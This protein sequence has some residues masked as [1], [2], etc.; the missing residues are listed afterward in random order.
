MQKTEDTKT[1]IMDVAERMIRHG[2]YNAFSFREIASE[3]GIKSASIHYHFPT[4]ADLGAAV[5]ARYADRF[6]D[7]L[8]VALGP[9]QPPMDNV[10]VLEAYVDAFRNALESDSTM[11]LCGML[12]AEMAGLPDPVAGEA[13]QF[14]ERNRDWLMTH[15]RRP[16]ESEAALETRALHVISALEGAMILA[17][18]LGDNGAFVKVATE[19]LLREAG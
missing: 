15:L 17:R 6:L 18:S 16:G 11:C 4:K 12:G 13:R 7:G 8:A 14:F 3:I 5:A 1:R 2:G 19:L 9:A 10:L